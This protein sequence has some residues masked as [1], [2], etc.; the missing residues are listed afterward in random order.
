MTEL[1]RVYPERPEPE[2]I[3]LSLAAETLERPP[4]FELTPQ[5]LE[6][7]RSFEADMFSNRN[8]F[9]EIAVVLDAL[10]RLTLKELT[11]IDTESSVLNLDYFLTEEGRTLL[12]QVAGVTL[13][14]DTIESVATFLATNLEGYPPSKV[15]ELKSKS[16]E[17]AKNML[18]PI[19][20][21]TESEP[22]PKFFGFLREPQKLIEKAFAAREIRKYY[23]EVKK[24]IEVSKETDAVK[25]A[26]KVV[27]EI[28]RQKLNTTIALIYQDA[29]RLMMQN[30][31]SGVDAYGDVLSQLSVVLPGIHKQTTAEQRLSGASD[32]EQLGRFLSRLDKYIRGA[33][34]SQSAPVSG[35]MIGLKTEFADHSKPERGGGSEYADI[36]LETLE[37]THVDATLAKEMIEQVLEKY[38]LLSSYP[39]FDPDRKEPAPDNKWQVYISPTASSLGVDGNKKVVNVP[40]KMYKNLT[41]TMPAG[42][43]PAL[44]HEVTHVLQYENAQQIGLSIIEEVGAARSGLWFEAGAKLSEI[45]AQQRLFGKPYQGPALRYLAAVEKRLE[46]GS[47]AECARAFLDQN[48]KE[49]PDK[50]H[51]GMAKSAISATMRI[52]RGGQGAIEYGNYVS[53]S[54]PLNYAEQ[55]LMAKNLPEEVKPYL[56]VG[57]VNLETLA[58]LHR[59]GLLSGV[60][61]KLPDP[62]PSQIVEQFVRDELL[63]GRRVAVKP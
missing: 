53:D 42:F 32:R 24:Q 33:N 26:E 17:Y 41:N 13:S 18:I 39:D 58:E 25:E 62:M 35:G 36:D 3:T 8:P 40:T 5:Q 11:K 55:Y 4:D 14:F 46:G 60:E 43:L 9:S 30:E 21:G 57:R 22:E 56:F 19:V 63:S 10:P 12:E 27:L 51:A 29:I 1:N 47:L 48:I 61:V 23:R 49:D 28:Y 6:Q 38:A 44:D 34:K 31:A 16:D 59:V 45:E 20:L 37:G 15:K 7:V 50:T 54:S 52:F 2:A